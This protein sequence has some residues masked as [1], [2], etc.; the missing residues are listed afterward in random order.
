MPDHAVD[1]ADRA[2]G[3][4][5][6][7]DGLILASPRS[8]VE[9]LH[10]LNR[11]ARI[12]FANREVEGAVSVV[13]D[14]SEGMNE[15]VQYLV[16]LGHRSICY[17]AGPSRSWSN[18]MRREAI[19]AACERHSAELIELGPFEPQI[20]AGMRAAD[21]IQFRGATAAIAYDDMIAL[22][23]MARLAECGIQ[24]GREISVIGIDDSPLSEVAYPLLTTIHLP[25][26]QLGWT[27]VDLLLDLI[28]P[29]GSD[30][31]VRPAGTTHKLEMEKA[32]ASADTDGQL[33]SVR[34]IWIGFLV[35]IQCT[36]PED[37]VFAMHHD[38]VFRPEVIQHHDR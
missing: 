37:S 24:V 17:L 1:E 4:A 35:L 30:G 19:V 25:G 14:E 23:V 28:G 34:H 16:S 12:V 7:A 15:A 20:Q 11:Q 22:G 29:D 31:D 9:Q 3:L 38:L 18:R 2:R 6:Q 36:H 13:I 21:L 10:E 26:A 5:R 8:Q 27:A 33:S 32:A